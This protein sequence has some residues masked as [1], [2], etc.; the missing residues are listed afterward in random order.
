MNIIAG[1]KEISK[2]S[3][4]FVCALPFF[5]A[6]ASNELPVC[7][8]SK[9]HLAKDLQLKIECQKSYL[10]YCVDNAQTQ[11]YGCASDNLRDKTDQRDQ[12]SKTSQLKISGFNVYNLGMEQD[13]MGNQLTIFKNPKILAEVI[14]QNDLVAAIELKHQATEDVKY[15]EA[16]ALALTLTLNDNSDLKFKIPVYL[17]VLKELQKKDPSW[18]LILST[19]LFGIS[20][21]DSL[22]NE[23]AAY[24]Y[25]SSL[26]T[27]VETEYCKELACTAARNEFEA[28]VARKPFLASFNAG[29]LDFTMAAVHFRYRYP[30]TSEGKIARLNEALY[31]PMLK[32]YDF[33]KHTGFIF[34]KNIKG[35][36]EE[37]HET[38]SRFSE[39]KSVSNFIGRLIFN[40]KRKDVLLYGD[41]N[42]A[43]PLNKDDATV[44][45]KALAKHDAYRKAWYDKKGVLENFTNAQPYVNEL[46]TVGKDTLVNAYDHFVFAKS[47]TLAGCDTQKAN[48]FNFTDRDVFPAGDT[49]IQQLDLNEFIASM[50]AEKKVLNNKFLPRYSDKKIEYLKIGLE[51]KILKSYKAGTFDVYKELI[52]D[53]LPIFMG[54]N[55]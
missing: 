6:F 37:K 2:V 11:K 22:N 3:L 19:D 18:T 4:M 20:D 7:E 25:K 38:S 50:R 23:L 15:N 14:S 5:G 32:V 30:T 1:Y 49:L 21:Q 55:I 39:A 53:H 9:K 47:G 16:L 42:L 26:V 36:V 33:E 40:S 27:P 31:G 35:Q 28:D 24:Y 45:Q 44:G 54:C 10:L 41:F 29:K 43:A 17:Q 34:D 12:T 51:N 52:S 8:F 46:S 48:V 13:M